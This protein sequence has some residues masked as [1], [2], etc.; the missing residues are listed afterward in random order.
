MGRRTRGQGAGGP[1]VMD[2]FLIFTTCFR[3]E[4]DRRMRTTKVPPP[5]A[6]VRKLAL[7]H[8]QHKLR[9]F[10]GKGR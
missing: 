6:A 8:E 5:A 1:L 7:H 4:L 10:I 9:F 3:G 2:D